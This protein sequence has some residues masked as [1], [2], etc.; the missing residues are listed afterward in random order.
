MAKIVWIIKP[1]LCILDVFNS[2]QPI[3]MYKIIKVVINYI[4]Y[5]ID[6]SLY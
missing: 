4:N 6:N 2:F 1:P 5:F 3:I